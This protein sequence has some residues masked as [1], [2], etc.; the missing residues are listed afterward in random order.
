MKNMLQR[1]KE[2]FSTKLIKNGFWLFALQVFNTIVPL[3]TLPYI[4]RVLGTTNYGIFSIALNWITYFQVIVEYGFGFTGA[5]KVSIQTDN[6]VQPLYSRIIMARLILLILSYIAMNIISLISKVSLERYI[7]MNILFLVIIGV[8]FQLTWLFQG[9]QDMK[10]ITIVNAISRLISVVM[11]F[12][13]VKSREN[14]YFY[15]FCYSSTFILSAL[16]GIILANI[17]YGLKVRFCKLADAINELK[18]GWYLFISQAMSKIISVVGTTVLG[19]V[20]TESAIGIYSAIYKLP[21]ILI[22]F[23]SPMSQALYP[24]ISIKFAESYKKGIRTLKNAALFIIPLFSFGGLMVIL[25][26][27]KIISI[28]FGKEYLEYE[29]IT[30]PLIIWM[31]LSVT[32]NLLGVQF[33]VASGNQKAYSQAISI[34]AIIIVILNFVMGMLFN[35][36]G[37]SIATMVGELVLTIILLI[38]VMKLHRSLL[39]NAQK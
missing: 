22:M 2:I 25:F 30:I 11:V 29:L 28:A 20:A 18:D 1:V 16:I 35:V 21:Y 38:K 19:F 17:K 13:L 39:T 8:S 4:T 37:I 9:K 10:F 23:F 24:D 5:R 32:N 34:G 36:Y 12:L 31:I 14:L 15:C 26:R 33:L 3:V 6:D 27:T 7:S